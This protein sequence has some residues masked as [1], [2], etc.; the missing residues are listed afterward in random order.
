[1]APVFMNGPKVASSKGEGLGKEFNEMIEV[2]VMERW[3]SEQNLIWEETNGK[4]QNC[5]HQG[6]ERHVAPGQCNLGKN[7]K[8]LHDLWPYPMVSARSA[9]HRGVDLSFP[10]RYR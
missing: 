10:S 9:H 3:G 8:I 6:D 1:M 4:S 7:L 5:R 2:Y